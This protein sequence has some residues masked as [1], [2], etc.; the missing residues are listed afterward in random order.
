[1][2]RLKLVI[3]TPLKPLVGSALISYQKEVLQFQVASNSARVVLPS[4]VFWLRFEQE[5]N[6]SKKGILSM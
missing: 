4:P 5:K 2:S 3:I 1:V 6:E